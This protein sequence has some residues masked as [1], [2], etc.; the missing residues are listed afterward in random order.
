MILKSCVL[1]A[2]DALL[3][4]VTAWKVICWRCDNGVV[5]LAVSALCWCYF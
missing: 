1:V 5:E 2:T 4:F 3:G